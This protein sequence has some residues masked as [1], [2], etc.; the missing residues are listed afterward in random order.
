MAG[1][2]RRPFHPPFFESHHLTSPRGNH[3]RLLN[4]F[5]RRAQPVRWDLL[6]VRKSKNRLNPEITNR[7]LKKI[8]QAAMR[9]QA[10]GFTA[11]VKRLAEPTATFDAEA[12][13]EVYCYAVRLRLEK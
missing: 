5:F 9:N 6:L 13:A 3:A 11:R 10:L 4:L 1:V 12:N 2:L 8:A 7:K